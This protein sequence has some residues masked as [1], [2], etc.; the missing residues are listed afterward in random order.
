MRAGA[1][2]DMYSARRARSGASQSTTGS[3]WRDD[4]YGWWKGRLAQAAR[5][6][7]AFRID[8][9]LGFFRIWQ[10]PATEANGLLG[11]F[12]PAAASRRADLAAGRVRRRGRALA[13]GP[14]RAG[15][16]AARC[17]RCRCGPGGRPVP[18]AHRQRG[19]LQPP[20][21]SRPGGRDPVAGRADA[22]PRGALPL[23]RGPGA[24]RGWR[25]PSSPPG[26]TSGPRPSTSL[27]DGR[28]AAAAASVPPRGARPRKGL[29]EAR[30]GTSSPWS[31]ARPTCSSAPR[32]SATCPT[33][34][35][36][37]SPTSRS[38]ACA[39]SAGPATGRRPGA[40]VHP[41][42]GVTRALS[43]CTPS[44]HDTSTLRGWWEEDRRSASVLLFASLG[45]HG[46]CPAR[47]SRGA[48]RRS[49]SS[50][51]SGRGSLLCV[52]QLQ[53]LL[54]LDPG[55]W[56]ADPR[57]DRINV[58]GHRR[59]HQLDLA[60]APDDRVAGRAPASRIACARW[61]RAAGGGRW[62]VR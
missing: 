51:H 42:G 31:G 4:G 49:C 22:G 43:V 16:R 10:M 36:A 34:C 48:A 38:S 25:G 3:A 17:P 52:F 44:V 59:G 11:W 37:C 56:T 13:L 2:P 39:S 1:P 30:A 26:T 33:A 19:S 5:F 23:A 28:K 60:H 12:D 15:R 9:V 46:P 40:P 7:H 6:F 27:D 24:A 50:M 8:H 57:G 61:R 41:P 58:P 54:D 47:L 21:R 14:A 18:P 45:V 32:T 20:A 35:P 55:L 53:E 29:G 62:E